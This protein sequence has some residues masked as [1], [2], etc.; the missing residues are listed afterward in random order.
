MQKG[1][2]KLTIGVV[3]S[4][5]VV[6]TKVIS[7]NSVNKS[8]LLQVVHTKAIV[9]LTQFCDFYSVLT[10]SYNCLILYNGM[11]NHGLLDIFVYNVLFSAMKSWCNVPNNFGWFIY[12]ARRKH[13]LRFI[14]LEGNT[15]KFE[16]K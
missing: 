11:F 15:T 5:A 16:G 13:N 10:G 12:F 9:A 1:I 6:K 8:C 3:L 7:C 4:I 2:Q 14:G